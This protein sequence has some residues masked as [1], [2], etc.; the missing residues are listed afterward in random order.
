MSAGLL[1]SCPRAALACL[2]GQFCRAAP[3]IQD[4][5]LPLAP[6]SLPHG[7]EIGPERAP[8]SINRGSTHLMALSTTFLEFFRANQTI[9]GDYGTNPKRKRKETERAKERKWCSRS[10]MS[11]FPPTRHSSKSTLPAARS[12]QNLKS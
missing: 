5:H 11:L 7:R 1:N 10:C 12:L 4:P 2:S 3:R 6:C 9:N 8:G